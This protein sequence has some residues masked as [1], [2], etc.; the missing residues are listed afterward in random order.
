MSCILLYQAHRFIKAV[1]SPEI[2]DNFLISDTLHRNIVFREPHINKSSDL[3]FKP[4][5]NKYINAL[6]DALIKLASIAFEPYDH[7]IIVF[8]LYK[9]LFKRW[10][11]SSAFRRFYCTHHF[12]YIMRMNALRRITVLFFKELV[13]IFASFF[14]CKTVELSP[15]FRLRAGM[16][17]PYH[18]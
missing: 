6:I 15:F 18:I 1:I 13:Q 10:N 16:K 2:C 11:F 12:F 8:C 3:I 4:R 14:F 7:R 17:N 5:I 9:R